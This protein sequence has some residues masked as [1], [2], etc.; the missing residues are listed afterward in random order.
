MFE[1]LDH[2]LATV[3]GGHSLSDGLT[4]YK[5][6]FGEAYI[7]S[8]DAGEEGGVSKEALFP[9]VVKS[10]NPVISIGKIAISQVKSRR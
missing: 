7:A 8:I 3:Q 1:V 5:K 2:T 9:I 4:P 10:H 6:V